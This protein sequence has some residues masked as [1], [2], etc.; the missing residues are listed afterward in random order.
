MKLNADHSGVCKFGLSPTDKANFK[1]VGENINIIY[2]KALKKGEIAS[3][4]QLR[5]MNGD[6][7]EAPMGRLLV[8]DPNIVGNSIL[9][10][11]GQGFT[12]LFVDCTN[13]WF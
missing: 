1:L 9:A 8:N 7:L 5:G 12:M 10:Q 13:T 11:V 3:S 6:S 2:Q 4:H